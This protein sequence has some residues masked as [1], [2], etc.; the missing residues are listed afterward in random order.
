M[1]RYLPTLPKTLE[2]TDTDSVNTSVS[3]DNSK[4]AQHYSVAD[5]EGEKAI[6]SSALAHKRLNM[7]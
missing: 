3:P 1:P 7:I 6:L 2:N 4:P 5:S